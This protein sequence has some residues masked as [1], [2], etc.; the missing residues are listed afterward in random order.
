M[1]K[2]FTILIALAMTVGAAA[3]SFGQGFNGGCFNCGPQGHS[4][5][6][7]TP[8]SLGSALVAW[9]KAD[10]GAI[11][12]G[13]GVHIITNTALNSTDRASLDAYLVSRQ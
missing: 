2:L 5:G 1:R 9:Y 7:W 4:R 6:A 10:V 13:T 8:A 3:S 12:T 11:N